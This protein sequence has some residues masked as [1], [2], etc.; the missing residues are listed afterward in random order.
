MAKKRSKKQIFAE[1]RA[2]Q[3]EFDRLTRKLQERI[4]FHKRKLREERSA[5]GS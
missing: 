4:A 1:L 3:P 2:Q 5:E